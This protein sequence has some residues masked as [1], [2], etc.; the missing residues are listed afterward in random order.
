MNQDDADVF[1]R[2]RRDLSSA[3]IGDIMDT[4]GFTHQFLPPEI[5]PLRDDMVI[6]GRAMT[7]LE[8]RR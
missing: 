5:Q 1:A 3:V 2:Y 7:V 4:L 6:C 8:A